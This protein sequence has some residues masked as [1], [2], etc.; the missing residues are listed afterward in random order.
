MNPKCQQCPLVV[1]DIIDQRCRLTP[2]EVARFRGDVLKPDV[3][4]PAADRYA[5]TRHQRYEIKRKAQRT[6]VH[7]AA[8]ARRAREY[9]ARKKERAY[10]A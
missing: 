1:C 2:G 3:F 8:D 4:K 7:R 10:A 6:D 9:R 5:M